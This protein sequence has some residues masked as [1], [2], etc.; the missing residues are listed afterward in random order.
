MN[1]RH[2][3]G[4]T[5]LAVNDMS[6]KEVQSDGFIKRKPPSWRSAELNELLRSLDSRADTNLKSAR[7]PRV[8][9]SPLKVGSPNGYLQWM[10]APEQ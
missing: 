2:R 10:I 4:K 3:N 7:K 1:R 5:L 6:D 9:G 8:E